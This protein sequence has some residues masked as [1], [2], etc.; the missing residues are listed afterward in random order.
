ML[1]SNCRILM[2]LCALPPEPESSF[3]ER[4]DD[5]D[6]AVP[7]WPLPEACDELACIIPDTTRLLVESNL[8]LRQSAPDLTGA[9]II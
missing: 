5:R 7:D 2:M 8:Q 6:W 9:G 3:L 4:L 1:V